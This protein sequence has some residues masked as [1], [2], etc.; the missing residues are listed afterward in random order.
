MIWF[1]IAFSNL[2]S[3][4]GESLPFVPTNA[5][6][7]DGNTSPKQTILSFSSSITSTNSVLTIYLKLLIKFLR[8]FFIIGTVPYI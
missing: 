2:I 5:L 6:D 1:F 3:V 4:L 7:N 8:I